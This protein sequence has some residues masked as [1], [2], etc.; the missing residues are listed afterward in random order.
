MQPARLEVDTPQVKHV[1]GAR[2][3]AR[4]D[5]RATRE[6]RPDERGGVRRDLGH[7][8]LRD[9][10]PAAGAR[11]GTHLDDVVGRAEHLD[12]VVDHDH[13]VAVGHEVAHDAQETLDVRRVQA[14]RGL[15]HHVEDSRGAV[16][17]RA[18]EL[19]ALALAGRER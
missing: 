2:L 16:P 14:D 19:D 17:H 1:I 9:H 15:V 4:G 7:A 6:V 10:A 18:R 3:Q 13:G 12:V 11:I 5:A 8:P